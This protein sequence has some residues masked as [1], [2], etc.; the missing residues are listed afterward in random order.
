[1]G[2]KSLLAVNGELTWWISPVFAAARFS[3]CRRFN[4]D[5]QS[6]IETKDFIIII[7]RHSV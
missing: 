5:G 6:M 3:D 4:G 2:L 7:I 1:M